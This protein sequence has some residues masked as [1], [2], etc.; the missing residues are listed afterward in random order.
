MRANEFLSENAQVKFPFPKVTSKQLEPFGEAYWAGLVTPE[1]ANQCF[2]MINKTLEPMIKQQGCMWGKNTIRGNLHII[3][4]PSSPKFADNE[5][6]D[7]PILECQYDSKIKD[8]G[9]IDHNIGI[10]SGY[11]Q[12]TQGLV[13]AVLKQLYHAMGVLHGHGTRSMEINDDRGHG[14]WQHIAHKLGA[15]VES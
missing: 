7:F 2:S 1:I 10:E 11:Q 12:H 3:P 13:T 9:T 4:D 8:D 14:V 5:A 6:D 15:T